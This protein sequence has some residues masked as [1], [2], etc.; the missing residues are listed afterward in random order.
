LRAELCQLRP[1]DA[2]D[3]HSGVAEP[4]REVLDQVEHR[5]L[6]PVHVIECDDD[7]L[8]DGDVNEQPAC[9]CEDLVAGDLERALVAAGR[10]EDLPNRRERHPLAVRRA[11]AD[12]DGRLGRHVAEELFHEPG[13][14]DARLA[15]HGHQAHAAACDDIR[16]R[17][18]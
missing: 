10:S 8:L 2:H 1:P 18:L 6:G 12:Q 7:R 17:G 3:E 4:R 14:A 15:E 16:V 13:L 9:R 11:A 5:L